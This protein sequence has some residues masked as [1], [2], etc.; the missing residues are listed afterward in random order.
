MQPH[1]PEQSRNEMWLPPVPKTP[2][3]G[4][5][6][7]TYFLTGVVIAGPLAVTLWLVWWFTDTVDQWVKPLVPP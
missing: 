6:I 3:F 4:A 7:R 2:G 5:R 1:P